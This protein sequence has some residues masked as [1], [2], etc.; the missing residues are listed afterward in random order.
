MRASVVRP[1]LN[2]ND[3]AFKGI[4][5]RREGRSA[6]LYKIEPIGECSIRNMNGK[7]MNSG[8]IAMNPTISL[9]GGAG[10]GAG[11]MYF[12]DPD[13][14][15][16]RRAMARDKARRWS[17]QAR[18]AAET[19]VRDMSNRTRGAMASFSS[20]GKPASEVSDWVLIERV[21]SALGMVMSHPSS[22]D[23]YAMNGAVT[24]RGPVL[25]EEVEP[26]V[27]A[28][29]RVDGVTHVDNQLE[30]HLEP[31]KIPDLQGTS[32]RASGP[33]FELMQSNWSP[34]ARA[35]MMVASSASLVYGLRERTPGT[36]LFALL[37][38]VLFL[39]S[40]TNRELATLFGLDDRWTD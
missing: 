14:G 33:R 10:F 3:R 36:I 4:K 16:R 39:R 15:R 37:G 27:S 9:I 22:I 31:G 40:A 5:G 7:H 21:R 19:T 34:A 35:I 6:A 29:R 18:G 2:Q 12:L 24:I 38:G 25:M 32:R 8:G 28:V 11:L 1:L 30:I 17:R 20:W 23:V 26:I 13:R